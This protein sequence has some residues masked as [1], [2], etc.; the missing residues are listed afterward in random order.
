MLTDDR[1]KNW[2]A[3]D[4]KSADRRGQRFNNC[5]IICYHPRLLLPFVFRQGRFNDNWTSSPKPAPTYQMDTDQCHRVISWSPPEA[6]AHLPCPPLVKPS[7]AF[8]TSHWRI[9]FFRCL[10]FLSP[11]LS[12]SSSL[13]HS[14]RRLIVA[15]RLNTNANL[16]M[17]SLSVHTS[18]IN[19]SWPRFIV[20]FS[21]CR[22]W[23]VLY[24]SAFISWR[25][26]LEL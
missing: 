9:T 16:S 18:A 23:H 14:S 12:V 2:K 20:N 11:T 8:L 21:Y 10:I 25:K 24:C 3:T 13:S 5:L 6:S 15:H 4:N 19:Q 7:L 1:M 22:I 17:L 26:M